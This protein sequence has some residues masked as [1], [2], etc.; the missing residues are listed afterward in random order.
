[1]ENK[2]CEDGKM[3]CCENKDGVKC[4]HGMANCCHNWMRCPMMK[5]IILI[6]VL[7]IVFCLGSQWGEMKSENRGG[8][9]FERGGM[10]N[11]G[12]GKNQNYNSEQQQATGSVTV[13]V[14]KPIAP[15]APVIPAPKQ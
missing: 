1:M 4:E 6:V 3:N 14:A 7:I 8:R 9:N 5:K 15:T 2:C 12:D 11:W 13:E 10:M